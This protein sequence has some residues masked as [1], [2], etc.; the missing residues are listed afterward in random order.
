MNSLGSPYPLCNA[1][2]LAFL[3][4]LFSSQSRIYSSSSREVS[5][6]IIGTYS[7]NDHIEDDDENGDGDG[8][9]DDDDDD[10]DL[11][12]DNNSDKYLND[13]AA[14]VRENYSHRY[15]PSARR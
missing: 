14:R 15:C 12:S 5:T 3:A 7:N 9:G 6:D 10:D 13:T 8:D 1:L 11:V 2:F 4:L